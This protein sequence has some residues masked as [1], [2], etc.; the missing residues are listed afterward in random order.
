MLQILF[1]LAT[2]QGFGISSNSVTPT[3]IDR[4]NKVVDWWFI[5]KQ[6]N[7]F[8]YSYKQAGDTSTSPLVVASGA[9]L[10]NNLRNALGATLHQVYLN[11]TTYAYV[12]YNDE[13]PVT[14]KTTG[15]GT[16][17]T[18]GGIVAGTTGAGFWLV[19]SVPKFP[20]LRGKDFTWAASDTYGQAMMCVTLDKAGIE[21]AAKQEQYTVPH[22]YD[23]N[24]PTAL[25]TKLPSLFALSNGK[26]LTGTGTSA[27][28]ITSSGGQKFTHF[29]KTPFWGEDFYE[30]LVAPG[31][32]TDLY[33]ETW[34]R[35]PFSPTFCTG[36]TSST[37]NIMNVEYVN[38]DSAHTY[39]YTHDHS[40]IAVSASSAK[41][42]VCV[43]GVN[44][45]P[46]Q[47]KRG[48]GAMCL[49]SKP[50][51]SALSAV[52]AIEDSCAGPFLPTPPPSPSPPS[53][54]PG[55]SSGCCY[56]S[57][58][59]CTKGD[60]CCKAGCKGDPNKCSYTKSG[61]S[62]AYGEKHNCTWVSNECIVGS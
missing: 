47:R 61:C 4:D 62:G 28:S 60:V 18:K 56:S 13:D 31:L 34:R 54:A 35:K 45:M 46:S 49:E 59:T 5:Y 14:G 39:K 11:K 36:N 20:D 50:L 12:L 38:F 24:F 41:P 23:K 42:F 8:E 19:H 25:E 16:G 37:Y 33:V 21:A 22:V 3:C 55:P 26:T 43:G 48:G 52:F 17:H 58:A 15:S 9:H 40:K 7:G 44:R 29:A 6:P 2:V 10:D 1:V 32:K 57:A 30:M 27:V 53:P 51:W